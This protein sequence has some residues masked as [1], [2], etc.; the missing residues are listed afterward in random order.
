MGATLGG[1]YGIILHQIFPGLVISPPAFAVAGMAGMVGGATGAAVT[2]IVMI[3]EMNLDYNVIIPMTITVAFSYGMR[4]LLSRE[5]IYTLKLARRGH[6]MPEALQANWH[7]VRQA[8]D[9]LDTQFATVPASDTLEKLSRLLA[10]EPVI[11][12]FVVEEEGRVTGVITQDAAFRIVGRFDSNT[13]IGK[14]AGQ[15]YLMV[16]EAMALTQIIARLRASQASIALIMSDGH[17]GKASHV[18]GLITKD[19]IVDSL[20]ESTEIFTQ[21]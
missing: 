20:A 10:E 8:R 12:S 21:E 15:D 16:P 17:A 11:Q 3:F 9:L 5:S 7:F 1:A 6:Y 18:M 19:R 13:P 4:K 2:A 14:V